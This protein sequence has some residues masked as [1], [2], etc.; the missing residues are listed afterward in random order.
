MATVSV[1]T[2]VMEGSSVE[3]FH[4]SYHNSVV[5]WG[6]TVHIDKMQCYRGVQ[7]EIF[8]CMGNKIAVP[9]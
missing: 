6:L 7:I 3:W 8:Q 5:H 4:Y 9:P 1:P 2:V